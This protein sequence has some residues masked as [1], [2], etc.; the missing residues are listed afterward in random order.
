MRNR[1]TLHRGDVERLRVALRGPEA[2]SKE[3]RPKGHNAQLG[4]LL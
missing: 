4:Q 3:Q 1:Q 2:I